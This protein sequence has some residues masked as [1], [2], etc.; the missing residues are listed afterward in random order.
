MGYLIKTE[1]IGA[2]HE[3]METTLMCYEDK[4]TKDIV[5]FCYESVEREIDGLPQH[6]IENVKVMEENN[7]NWIPYNQPP[8]TRGYIL[9]SFENFSLPL[10]GRYEEDKNGGAYYIGD[11]EYS[12]VAQDIIVNAWMPLPKSYKEKGE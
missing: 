12:C 3:D 8:K 7:S 10:V 6:R 2:I 4:R 5:R 9:L 1:V 11:E